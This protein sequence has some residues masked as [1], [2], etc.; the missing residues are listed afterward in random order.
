M[1]MRNSRKITPISAAAS[2]VST[3][4]TSPSWAG[5]MSTPATRKPTIGTTLTRTDR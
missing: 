4:L 5:P 1:P 2:T 3:S